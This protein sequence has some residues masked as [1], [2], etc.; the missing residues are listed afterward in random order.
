MTLVQIGGNAEL[1]RG[2]EG[3]AHLY[4]HLG[5]PY[6]EIRLA[7]P[8]LRSQTGKSKPNRSKKTQTRCGGGSEVARVGSYLVETYPFQTYAFQRQAGGEA[9][10]ILTHQEQ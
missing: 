8:R 7:H 6:N 4:P 9:A 3:L 10:L 1:D 5:V 2:M